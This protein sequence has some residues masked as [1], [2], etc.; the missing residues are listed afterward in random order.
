MEAVEPERIGDCTQRR[1]QSAKSGGD[2]IS[3]AIA[4]RPNAALF[5]RTHRVPQ[6]IP[7]TSARR[8]LPI[9]P[10][11]RQNPNSTHLLRHNLSTFRGQRA[12]NARIAQLSRIQFT[13]SAAIL[14]S[15]KILRFSLPRFLSI[16]TSG[17]APRRSG[18]KLAKAVWA[19][20][21]GVAARWKRVL[22]ATGSSQWIL[23]AFHDGACCREARR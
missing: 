16:K 19:S 6:K 13:K 21:T 22:P 17:C 12:L 10:I 20:Q 4:A 23:A 2:R 1:N 11:Y 8:P 9:R 7:K 5:D 14:V 18:T 3:Q 15:G